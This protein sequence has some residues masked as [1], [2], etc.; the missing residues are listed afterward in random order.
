MPCCPI[1]HSAPGVRPAKS[2]EWR[3]RQLLIGWDNFESAKGVA[4]TMRGANLSEADCGLLRDFLGGLRGGQTK[5]LITSRSPEK[6][7]G[8]PDTR[9]LLKLPGMDGEE[10]WE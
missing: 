1:T 8:G 10:R 3:R 4:G 2:R 6:W 9:Y 7:L 5:V